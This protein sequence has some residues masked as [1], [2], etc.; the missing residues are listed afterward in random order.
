MRGGGYLQGK[1]H[2]ALWDQK[3]DQVISGQARD[4]TFQ[5]TKRKGKIGKRRKGATR[6]WENLS[7]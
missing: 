6:V 7:D 3:L 4:D 1:A 5:K 2:A